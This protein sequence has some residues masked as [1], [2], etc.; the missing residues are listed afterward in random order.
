MRRKSTSVRARETR[1]KKAAYGQ[2]WFDELD[3]LEDRELTEEELDELK[4]KTISL[5]TPEGEV[6]MY[7]NND[8]ESFWYYSDNKN[9]SNRTLDAVKE[10]IQ[11]HTIANKF[12]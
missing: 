6:L 1:E 8:T 7:Y 5:D 3:E 12:A 10:S 11:L 2:K 4:N 9:I